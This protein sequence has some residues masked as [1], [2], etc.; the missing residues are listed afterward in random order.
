MKLHSSLYL[1]S[2]KVFGF[3]ISSSLVLII[4]TQQPS[5][6][7]LLLTCSL[8]NRDGVT[9]RFIFEY[10]R[11]HNLVLSRRAQTHQG[12]SVIT[13]TQDHLQKRNTQSHLTS[14]NIFFLQKFY[15]WRMLANI[16]KAVKHVLLLFIN[17]FITV[18][19]GGNLKIFMQ[20]RCQLI[21]IMSQFPPV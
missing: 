12:V 21:F 7:G 18:F 19:F 2:R 14:K 17:C 13:S 1:S 4:S 16:F 5:N 6:S 9:L 20:D 15:F 3:R 10:G 11:Q 8:Y